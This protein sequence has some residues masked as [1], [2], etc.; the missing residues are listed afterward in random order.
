MTGVG[1]GGAIVL[2]HLER[3][4]SDGRGEGEGDWGL[5]AGVWDASKQH[6][7]RPSGQESGLRALG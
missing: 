7:A 1:T 5:E 6:R 4:R 3:G 2:I